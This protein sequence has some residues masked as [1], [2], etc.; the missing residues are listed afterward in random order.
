M[1][2]IAMTQPEG[3]IEDVLV[4]VGKFIFPMDFLVIDMEVDKQVT[5]L[6]SRPFLATSEAL[7]D[8]KK[9]EL[10]LRV[11]IEKVQFNF[12]Q[13]LKQPDFEGAHCM[14]VDGVFSDRKEMKHD[15]M[16]QDPLEE[17]I[18]KS[19]YKENLE[20]EKLNASAE[21]IETV[22]NLSKGNEEDVKSNEVRVQDA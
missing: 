17:C 22:L 14:R 20:G 2:D 12:N 7:I 6:L 4:K 9:R 15:F 3:I 19:L 10:T 5:L 11:G 13:S 16:N 8:V 18:F 1:A 21:L